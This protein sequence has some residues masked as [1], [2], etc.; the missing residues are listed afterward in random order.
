[1]ECLNY[2]RNLT[3]IPKAPD[4]RYWDGSSAPLYPF[5]YG[6]SYSSFIDASLQV[7]MLC[8][9]EPALGVQAF[10]HRAMLLFPALRIFGP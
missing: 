2:A 4:T 5:G 7:R 8:L 10:A 6:L 1:M 9:F 3:Q